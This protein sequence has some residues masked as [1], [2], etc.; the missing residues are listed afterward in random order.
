MSIVGVCALEVESGRQS[1]FPFAIHDGNG[2]WVNL[3][4]WLENSSF[5]IALRQNPATAKKVVLL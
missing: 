4:G 2:T 5:A 1:K 3:I